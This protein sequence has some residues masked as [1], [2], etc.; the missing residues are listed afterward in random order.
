MTRRIMNGARRHALAVAFGVA[1]LAAPVVRAEFST[2]D[3][4]TISGGV[5]HYFEQGWAIGIGILACMVAL[6]AIL[7][8]LSVFRKR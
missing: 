6:A 8:G 3:V 5:N 1:A 7:K 2:N 4:L